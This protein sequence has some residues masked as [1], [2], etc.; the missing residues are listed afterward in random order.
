LGGVATDPAGN[1]L[2]GGRT[3]TSLQGL[4]HAFVAKYSAGGERLWTRQLGTPEGDAAWS[5]ATDATGNVV[6]SGW[7]FGS[8]GGPKQGLLDAFVAKYSPAGKRLW[9]RQFGTPEDDLS[10]GV[11]T[12]AA[13]NVVIDGITLGSLGG[14]NHGDMDL[15]IVKLRP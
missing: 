2:I 7:T 5:V 14:P 15:F 13:G 6:I 1:V 12:D 11:A 10:S 9:T 3:S 8:L 4:P